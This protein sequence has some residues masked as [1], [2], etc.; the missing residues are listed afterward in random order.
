MLVQRVESLKS[1]VNLDMYICIIHITRNK[2]ITGVYSD[3]LEFS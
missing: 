3:P 1:S 2:I